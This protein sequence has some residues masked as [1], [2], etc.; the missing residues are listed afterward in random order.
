MHVVFFF[1]CGAG[2][3]GGGGG[4]GPRPPMPPLYPPLR[5][6]AAFKQVIVIMISVT[7][8]ISSDHNKERR[9]GRLK[10]TNIDKF[11]CTIL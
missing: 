4:G 1:L 3:G 8:T 7:E 6:V 11:D 5:Q 9:D 10:V 2:G